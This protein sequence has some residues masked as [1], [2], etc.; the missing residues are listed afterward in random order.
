MNKPS[1]RGEGDEHSDATAPDEE[2]DAGVKAKPGYVVLARKYRPTTFAELVGQDA[3]VRTLANAF[4]AG[5][6]AQAY[7]LTGVRGVGKTTTARLIARALNYTGPGD[8]PVANM[9]APGAHCTAILKARHPDVIEM[10]A[11]SRTGVDD[12]RE[13]IE[14]VRYRPITARYKVYIVDEVHMLSKAAFNALLKTL[15]EPP[16]HVKFIFATTEAR[17]VPLTVLSRCQR[18]DLRRL[19]AA[20]LMA[21]FGKVA[22]AERIEIDDEAL[23]LLARAAQGSVRDGLSLLDQAIAYGEAKLDAACLRAMLGLADRSQVIDLFEAVMGGKIAE[24]LNRFKTLHDLGADAI[25][26]LSDMAET[27]HWVTRLKAAGPSDEFAHT[28]EERIHGENLARDLG[29]PALARAWQML[30]KGMS[31]VNHAPNPVT[32][33]EMVLIRM[34]YAAALPTPNEVIRTITQAAGNATAKP[35]SAPTPPSP[36][37]E[38]EPSPVSRHHTL[39][40]HRSHE[41]LTDKVPSPSPRA[42]TLPE[43][44]RPGKAAKEQASL[45]SFSD[46]ATYIGDKRDVRLKMAVENSIRPVHFA[47][48][49]LEFALEKDAPAGLASELAR[50]LQSWTGERWRVIVSGEAGE[51]PLAEQARERYDRLACKARDNAVVNAVFAR[52]PHAEIIDVG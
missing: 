51:K 30:L 39:S 12:I 29:V 27:T 2:R 49:R 31:E 9:D 13:L 1:D 37:A 28:R 17:R 14:T 11:A 34:A 40:S 6:I 25:N 19:D 43:R 21:H 5:R 16:E 48:G 23:K 26:I 33:A 52:F 42:A 47:P 46:I 41:S 3:V 45:T 35:V 10:D 15:E 8:N 50:K 20:A 7:M 18:F 38:T 4:A 44:D 24:A 32:A 22:R 36:V